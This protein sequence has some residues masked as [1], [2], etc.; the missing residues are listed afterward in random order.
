[1]VMKQNHFWWTLLAVLP[2]LLAC[3]QDGAG[4]WL[5]PEAQ[6]L[7]GGPGKDGIP[8]VDNPQFTTVNE[9]DPALFDR[10]LVVGVRVGNEVRA[11]PHFI[12]DWHEIVNDKVNGLPMAINYCPLTGTAMAWDR[13][14]NG[15][16]TT[17]GV[18]G[19]LYQSNIIPF[20]RLTE[21]NWSQLEVKAVE[22]E[23]SGT[24]PK[25][26]P[27]VETTWETWK[28]MY[29]ETK[30][31]TRETGFARSYGQYPYGD[32]RINQ[33]WL[34]FPVTNRDER[35]PFKERVH[36]IQIDGTMQSYRQSL[37]TDSVTVLNDALADRQ[38]VVAG[39]EADNLFVSY[40]RKLSDGTVLELQA[41]QGEL[42]I[43]M[44]DQEG[45]RWDVF[46]EALSGPRKGSQ[47]AVYP[48]MMGYW[49]SFG[50]FYPNHVLRQ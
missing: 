16:E 24:A 14:I 7:D 11:Y 37:F 31:M 12:L 47:L 9:A 1:M 23:L 4:T 33:D 26:Y 30:V 43:L 48:S 44:T 34:I 2:L 40:G 27:I 36:A 17:F 10:E 3:N 13:V 38:I 28:K 45:N 29:P 19:L 50:A 20:D 35:L 32:Y 42:P 25:V 41:L 21:S 6:V 49:F 18:S 22:G 8:S 5:I 15:A 46:G 39:S